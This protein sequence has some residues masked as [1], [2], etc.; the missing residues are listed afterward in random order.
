MGMHTLYR[1]LFFQRGCDNVYSQQQGAQSLKSESP[2][3]D[4]RTA[5]C[6]TF[7]KLPFSTF[8]SFLEM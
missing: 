5:D 6:M 1:Q 4:L 2:R 7:G 3:L 8:L